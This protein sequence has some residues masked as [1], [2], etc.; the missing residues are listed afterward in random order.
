VD[1]WQLVRIIE[2]ES[3]RLNGKRVERLSREMFDFA[4][5]PFPIIAAILLMTSIGLLWSGKVVAALANSLSQ[6][7]T[8]M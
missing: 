8:S 2:R 4:P 7:E 6:E 1:E 3:H 5:N